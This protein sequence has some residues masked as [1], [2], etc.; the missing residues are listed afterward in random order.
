MKQQRKEGGR[1]QDRKE[2][3]IWKDD[4]NDRQTK[5]RK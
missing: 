4:S 3:N 2:E 5:G 1:E